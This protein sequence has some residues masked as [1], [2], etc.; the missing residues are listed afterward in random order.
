MGPFGWR[1]GDMN[2]G[3]IIL[4]GV[5]HR[6]P[7]GHELLLRLL[8]SLRPEALCVEFSP[9][10][11]TWREHRSAHLRK[12][13]ERI[14]E[15]FPPE[16]KGHPQVQLIRAA[17]EMPF[18]YI[19]PLAYAEIHGTPLHLVDYNW[20]SRAHLPLYE[21]EILTLD[22]IGA[23][24]AGEDRPLEEIVESV[25][26][27]AMQCLEDPVV[28]ARWDGEVLDR[29]RERF[30]ACRVRRAAQ[31]HAQIVYVGGWE[32]L[33]IGREDHSLAVFLKNLCPRRMLLRGGELPPV[34]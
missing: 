21:S 25:Y 13:L 4:V 15:H 14:L 7:E 28:T 26:Q 17:L 12:R 9:L 8:E 31:R 1:L 33:H 20:L 27:R 16:V 29:K 22:N 2:P 30:L 24:V 18:E 34:Q 11:L 19:A 23:L 10:G 5:V 6:D 32:H 3:S